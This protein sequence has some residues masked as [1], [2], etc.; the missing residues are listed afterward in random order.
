[1]PSRLA[2][3]LVATLFAASSA[4]ITTAQQGTV[5]LEL[6]ITQPSTIRS[7]TRLVEVSVVALDSHGNP[8]TGLTKEDFTL[9]DEGTAQKISVFNSALPAPAAPAHL[10]P[11]NAFT[12][13]YDLKGQDPGA[14][15]IILF[16]ALNSSAEDQ[17]YARKQILKFLQAMKPQDH[18]AIYALTTKLLIL[19]DFTQDSA[20]LVNAVSRFTPK[21]TAAFDASNAGMVDSIYSLSD[22]GT[23]LQSTALSANDQIAELNIENRVIST[24]NAISAIANHVSAMPGRKSL[25][26]VSGGFPLQ[27]SI[28]HIGVGGQDTTSFIS[29]ASSPN[30]AAVGQ[31]VSVPDIK[32]A[33]RALN[34]SNISIYPVDVHGVELS[35]GMG[36][37]D[38]LPATS[39]AQQ[40][41]FERH[42]RLDSFTTLADRTGG[43]AFFGNNDIRDGIRRA[44]DDGRYAYTIGFYPDHNTWDGKFR[45]LKIQVKTPGAH[46]RYRKGYFAVPELSDPEA[47]VKVALQDAAFSP[48]EATNLSLIVLGKP[49]GPLQDRKLDLRIALD[50]K[51]FQLQI[52]EG[53]HK[54]ALDMMFVQNSLTGE[55]LGAEKQHFDINFEEKQFAYM[56]TAGLILERHLTVSPQATEVRV[57]VRDAA[58][59][60][61]GSVII[62]VK[63]FFPATTPSTNPLLAPVLN[64]AVPPGPSPAAVPAPTAPRQ[65]AHS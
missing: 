35:S 8:I 55:V 59:G 58:S 31:Q 62:P 46:L 41:F 37:G 5:T 61:L 60:S 20:A 51:Q 44:F 2:S 54:G 18:I 57:I 19:H 17:A 4:P 36:P 27:I 39:L 34:R 6:P 25:V 29:T 56:A 65:F 21:E 11:A 49:L 24:A 53:R 43:V 10:L 38:R 13:R 64:P 30:S 47:A 1:M 16:D 9:Q 45:G 52:S 26:W 48:L 63:S 40:G 33:I 3:V 7:A 32:P 22:P 14:V 50:P 42:N 15:T 28:N 12:N 23:Q